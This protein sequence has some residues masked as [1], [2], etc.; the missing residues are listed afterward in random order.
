[1]KCKIILSFY[2]ETLL[3]RQMSIYIYMHVCVYIHTYVELY[4]LSCLLVLDVYDEK[5]LEMDGNH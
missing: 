4:A 1:M 3:F 5:S 2:S